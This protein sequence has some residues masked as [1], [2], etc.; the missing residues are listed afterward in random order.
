V[1][2]WDGTDGGFELAY[3]TKAEGKRKNGKKVDEQRDKILFFKNGIKKGIIRAVLEVT[4]TA[5]AMIRMDA[6]DLGNE[7][8]LCM[9]FREC[10]I[11]V[12]KLSKD[13]FKLR[14]D[15]LEQLHCLSGQSTNPSCAK[16]DSCLSEKPGQKD[17]MKTYLGV[18]LGNSA[19]IG[20]LVQEE[21]VAAVAKQSTKVQDCFDPAV[22]DPEELDCNCMDVYE[23]W[24]D[25]DNCTQEAEPDKTCMTKYLCE[26]VPITC[27]AWRS[28]NC[29]STLRSLLDRSHQADRQ[30]SQAVTK[31]ESLDESFSGK[32]CR[33]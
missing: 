21:Q 32:R 19:S 15:N 22:S 30:V 29:P 27:A 12:G 13:D 8:A 5:K 4:S 17:L 28:A 23:E 1:E 16:F 33:R 3:S 18:A 2:K 25:T 9:D 10:L 24:K 26:Q 7:T 6:Q 14:E 31:Q 20:S 11:S